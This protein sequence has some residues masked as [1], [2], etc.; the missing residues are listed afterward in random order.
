MKSKLFT[1]P[2][3]QSPP[4]RRFVD[5]GYRPL[6]ASLAELRESIDAVDERI[7]ALLAERARFVKD[8]TRFKRDAYQVAAPA[9]QA[10]VFAKAR[11]RATNYQAELPGLPD[12]AEA[13]Y[14]AM[15]GAFV[16]SE[17]VYFRETEL[18][19]ERT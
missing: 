19:E 11:A 3:V 15:V 6:A 7:I 1:E 10:E 9:R 12:V 5:P 2:P 14:R 13:T 18:I 4:V 16:A 8:A 17:Q